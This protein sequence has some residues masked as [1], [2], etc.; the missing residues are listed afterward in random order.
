M[1]GRAGLDRNSLDIDVALKRWPPTLPFLDFPRSQ[2]EDRMDSASFAG[3]D[4]F[5]ALRAAADW[6]G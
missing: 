5:G 4:T 2:P 6:A 3:A 1:N